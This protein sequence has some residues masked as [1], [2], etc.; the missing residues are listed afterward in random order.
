MSLDTNE[1]HV[2]LYDNAG[3]LIQDCYYL[4]NILEKKL[5]IYENRKI[6]LETDYLH[7]EKHGDECIF[8]AAGII[9]A[10]QHYEHHQLEGKSTWYDDAGN[11]TKTSYYHH[12]QLHGLSCIYLNNKIIEK[13][14]YRKGELIKKN[15]YRYFSSSSSC[16]SGEKS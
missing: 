3:A 9:V 16:L 15:I 8:N 5:K 12:N 2:V 6:Y 4:N 7:G 1:T 13:S 14:L 11:L 10:R